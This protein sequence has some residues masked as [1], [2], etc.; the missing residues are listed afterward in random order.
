M[1]EVDFLSAEET[2]ALK[3]LQSIE[4]L[5]QTEDEKPLT[6]YDKKL[7]DWK[8]RNELKD[9]KNI[10]I[11][12][13]T[14]GQNSREEFVESVPVDKYDFEGLHAHIK[15]R[16]GPGDYRVRLRE[17]KSWAINEYLCVREALDEK[18]EYTGL[19]G[20][21]SQL[22]D[23]IKQLNNRPRNDNNDRMQFLQEMLIMKQLFSGGEQKQ[24]NGL[25][26]VLTLITGLKSAGLIS[27][28]GDQEKEPEKDG[29]LGFLTSMGPTLESI[30]KT[31]LQNRQQVMQPQFIPPVYPSQPE[32]EITGGLPE[33]VKALV[34]M[35]LITLV[36]AAEKNANPKMY[37]TWVLDQ[38]PADVEND[39]MDML[40]ADNWLDTLDTMSYNRARPYAAWFAEVRNH[41]FAE[42][43][44]GS[45]DDSGNTHNDTSGD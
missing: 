43:T 3:L 33:N 26:E 29:F 28:P 23:Q 5:K 19:D 21:V 40:E 45:D 36:N 42:F 25:T 20:V 14:N 22:L 9:G 7:A 32:P 8:D 1:A 11:Y 10:S 4:G 24:A 44:D 2:K 18:K 35:S 13:L 12:V 16:W 27:T 41:I 31:T 34:S 17:G 37:A 38:L 6:S 15:R 39:F 30:A